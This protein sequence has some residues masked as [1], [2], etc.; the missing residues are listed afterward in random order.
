MHVYHVNRK[1]CQCGADCRTIVADCDFVLPDVKI[2]RQGWSGEQTSADS[3]SFRRD[4]DGSVPSPD[5]RFIE[6]GQDLFRAPCS[7]VAYWRERI[8]HAEYGQAH[9]DS[10][11]A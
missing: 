4:D 11:K 1:P 6:R 5:Q 9:K 8:S 2:W 7:A 3:R 10:P